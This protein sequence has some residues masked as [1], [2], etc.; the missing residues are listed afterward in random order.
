MGLECKD[1]IKI[2]PSPI[3]GLNFPALRGLD[4][5][6]KTGEL[7]SII[8]PSGAGKTTLLKLISAFDQPSS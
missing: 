3:E 4:L 8:G 2:Y 5:S 6:V 7:F 1:L